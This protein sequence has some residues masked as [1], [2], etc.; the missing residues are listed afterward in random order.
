MGSDRVMRLRCSAEKTRA[1]SRSTGLT[2][3]RGAPTKPSKRPSASSCMNPS[4]RF[5]TIT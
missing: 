5:L 3:T 4:K 2:T 1:H